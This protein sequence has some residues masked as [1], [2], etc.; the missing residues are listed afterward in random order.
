MHLMITAEFAKNILGVFGERFCIQKTHFFFHA[1]K[2]ISAIIGRKK[3]MILEETKQTETRARN[4][5]FVVYPD[6]C[7]SDWL[8]ILESLNVPL[9][10]SPLHTVDD[11]KKHHHVLVCGDKK[12]ATQIYDEICSRLG[13][14]VEIDGK[15]SVKGVTH[16]QKVLNLKSQVRY[17]VHL[18]NPKKEQFGS[19]KEEIK[20]FGGFDA[21]K[22]FESKEEKKYNGVKG[23]I[24]IIKEFSFDSLIELLE[25]L[26]QNHDDLFQVCCDNA[27]LVT[28]LCNYNLRIKKNVD[29]VLK[30]Q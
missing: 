30:V 17:L 14:S 3:K 5:A 27:Y 22:Y 4:W 7:R 18:D 15:V 28:Q 20:F 6:E 1:I 16:P 23:I 24:K 25:Y 9:A 19:W 12:S 21:T 29:K 8:D 13:D 11:E 10:V 26:G 2:H